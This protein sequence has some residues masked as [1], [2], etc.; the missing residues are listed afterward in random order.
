MSVFVGEKSSTDVIDNGTMS[1]DEVVAS[2]IHV[3]FFL[4]LVLLLFFFCPFF[5]R[6]FLRLLSGI[7]SPSRA[8]TNK[9]GRK[10]DSP[11]RLISLPTEMKGLVLVESWL[12]LLAVT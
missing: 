3:L 11:T 7:F 4:L 1:E 12:L 5:P 2:D 8:Q 6:G 9:N 10:A